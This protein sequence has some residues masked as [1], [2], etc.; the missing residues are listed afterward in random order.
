MQET[1]WAAGA[2]DPAGRAY[3]A[4]P[5]PLADG[6]GA[7]CLIPKNSTPLWALQASPF[8]PNFQPSPEL[9]SQLRPCW[10]VKRVSTFVHYFVHF[11]ASLICYFFIPLF[12]E[13]P[14]RLAL[15]EVIVLGVALYDGI[16]NGI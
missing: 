14:S 5:D 8:P 1:A 13:Y 4:P 7:D 12:C 15:F 16:L 6:E 3:S 9:K 2:P 10:R 11:D